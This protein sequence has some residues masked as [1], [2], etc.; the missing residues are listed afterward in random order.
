[1]HHFDPVLKN[2]VFLIKDVFCYFILPQKKHKKSLKA[3]K[4]ILPWLSC[5][6]WVCTLLNTTVSGSRYSKV[7]IVKIQTFSI[8]ECDRNVFDRMCHT[9]AFNLQFSLS[10]FVLWLYYFKWKPDA[11]VSYY[12]CT[13]KSSGKITFLTHTK[14]I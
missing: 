2:K 13:S 12:S 4:P 6:R 11:D 9:N 3:M 7:S 1:M 8:S 14:N 5:S 10:H